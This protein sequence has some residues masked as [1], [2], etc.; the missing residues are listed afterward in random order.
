MAL[1]GTT[2]R[3]AN[4]V[5]LSRSRAAD[6]WRPGYQRALRVLLRRETREAVDAFL[7]DTDSH[8]DFRRHF[9][10]K[11][12]RELETLKK[13]YA[14]SMVLAGYKWADQEF[15]EPT[16]GKQIGSPGPDTPMSVVIGEGDEFL[17]R[18]NF[19]DIDKWVETT[20]EAESATKAR[21][22][23][24]ILERAAKE[25]RK[26]VG[27][28]GISYTRGVTVVE[29]AKRLRT[30]GLVSDDARASML[31]RTGTIW[32]FNEGAQQRYRTAGVTAEEWVITDD[33]A[34]CPFCQEMDGKIVRLDDPF[35]GVDEGV[36][37]TDAETG[38]QS[39]LST[40]FDVQHPPLHPN[41]R[42]TIVPVLPEADTIEI[43]REVSKPEPAE[44]KKPK[45]KKPVMLGTQK[46]WIESLS[47][48]EKKA[49]KIW[50]SDMPWDIRA[51]SAGERVSKKIKQIADTFLSALRRAPR[52]SGPV[53]RGLRDLSSA[54]FKKI[55]TSK[56][57]TLRAI[58]SSS[59]SRD[60]AE[61]FIRG[62][63]KVNQAASTDDNV[64]LRIIKQRHGVAFPEEF[65]TF[66][67]LQEILLKKGTRFRVVS[68]KWKDG[69]E[70]FILPITSRVP[71]KIRFLEITV[72]E[73]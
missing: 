10:T 42:C 30:S 58:A 4:Q 50:G 24:T 18:G 23:Q 26:V 44:P 13:R 55:S 68:R 9:L 3:R 72:E 20:A 37:G 60:V 67:G 45:K 25:T 53:F 33:D 28:D 71:R 57:I 17:I 43:T 11:W 27:L 63:L 52:K 49:L 66:K 34:A 40:P 39:T 73:I 61:G 31:A 22:L 6:R 70:R 48:S 16:A 54:D 5:Q 8:Y 15:I 56:E 59:Q 36:A 69:R 35:V 29:I 47:A 21:R 62:T 19:K 51:S 1:T 32:A 7:A 64:L 2:R 41:C 46:E 65:A 38:K 12:T 14:Y